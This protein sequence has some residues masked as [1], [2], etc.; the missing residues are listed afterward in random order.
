MGGWEVSVVFF[1]CGGMAV[2]CSGLWLVNGR[3]VPCCGLCGCRVYGMRCER[4][5]EAWRASLIDCVRYGACHGYGQ[6]A[7]C[8]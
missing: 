6:R 7:S 1:V 2:M 4:L 3:S 5:I 8:P